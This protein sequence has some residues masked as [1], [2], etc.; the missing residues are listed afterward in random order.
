MGKRLICVM[1]A[2]LTL[3]FCS[4]A[5]AAGDT[6]TVAVQADIR[7]LDPLG[8]S[9]NVTAN[10][11]LQ[12]YE[13]LIFIGPDGKPQ[14]MLAE[15]WEQTSPTTYVYHIRQ[16][17]KF[18]NGDEAT[19]EDV[20][21]TLDRAMGPEGFIAHSYIRDMESVDVIDRYTVQINLKNPSTP[22]PL[23]F[24]ESWAGIVS[25]RAVTEGTNQTHPIGTGPFKFVGWRKSDRLILERFDDY[26]GT[27]P[28]FKHLI[29][30]AIPE[31]ST[32]TIE[33]QSGA[34][35]VAYNIHFTD[36]KR[37]EEDPKLKL[38]RFPSNRNELFELNTS[39]PGM[40]D[41]R[42]RRAIK[43]AIDI[44]GLQK[45]VFRGVGSAP[46]APISDG[47]QYSIAGELP[48]PEQDV[49][50]AKKLL[51][52]AGVKGLKLVMV[53]YELKEYI[54]CATIVQSMLSDVGIDLEVRVL[55]IGAYYDTL[56]KGDF[57]IGITAWGYNLPDASFLFERR[58][59]SQA[60]GTMNYSRYGN[61]KFDEQLFIARTTPDGPDRAKAFAEA[62]RMLLEDLPVIPWSIGEMIVGTSAKVENFEMCPRDVYRLW[63]ADFKD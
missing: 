63:V 20:K 8:A 14:P 40:N 26:Y 22:F 29:L 35:D 62:Q 49:E 61:P 55:E 32:R 57:D 25:K 13:N 47:I 31:A 11:Q 56:H 42:V 15:S 53:T 46:R 24:G 2:L 41:I 37:I 30:R 60:L 7:A 33:L 51:A 5:F 38:L 17:V 10:A 21:F 4:L 43:M 23:A 52:E 45:A 36:F 34:A 48:L 9:D 58:F 27:K 50:G 6:M 16:G 1:S 18:H 19:A 44:P 54:D 3:A 39:R 59:S 28:D 12:I